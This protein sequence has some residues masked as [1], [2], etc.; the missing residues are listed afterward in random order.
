MRIL[1]VCC[2]LFA[3]A[4]GRAEVLS[5][6]I[7]V[8]VNS[9]YGISEPWV[10]IREGLLRLDYIESVSSQP[11]RKSATGE[12][13]TKGGRVP[14]VEALAKGIREIGAGASLRGVEPTI[15]G[16]LEK[17]GG[18]FVL[19]VS[20][21]GEVLPLA[22]VTNRVHLN[23]RKQPEPLVDAETNAFTNLTAKWSGQ[24]VSV[25]IT[26]PL[27]KPTGDSAA[28]G[29]QTLQVRVFDFQGGTAKE[30]IK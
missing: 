24:P 1:L 19:R 12:L 10:I 21:T 25:H 22:P 23:G 4:F 17:Q 3:A 14:D 11:D 16:D 20:K 15:D 8:D 7:G 26:G 18:G 28:A 13:R 5:V 2:L 29:L 9:P 30:T 6:T 27:A